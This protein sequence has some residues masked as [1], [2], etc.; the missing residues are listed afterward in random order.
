DGV[1][2][3]GVDVRAVGVA[4]AVLEPVDLP[5]GG[6]GRE[7]ALEVAA[8][9]AVPRPV[10]RGRVGGQAQHRGLRAVLLDHLVGGEGNHRAGDGAGVDGRVRDGEAVDGGV[11]DREEGGD[12]LAVGGVERGDAVAVHPVDRG[13]PAAD[14]D[15]R[16]VGRGD[17]A[18]DHAVD[19]R[20]ER[21]DQGAGG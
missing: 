4:V 3:T 8:R 10:D 16:A 5:G 2:L 13:E 17:H 18:L 15:P 14:V 9:V 21:G 19:D 11:D 12:E 6:V 7:R 20:R 1:D